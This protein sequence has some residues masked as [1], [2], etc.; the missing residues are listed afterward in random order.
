MDAAA[1]GQAALRGCGCTGRETRPLRAV[2]VVT[3]SV[4]DGFPVP[5]GRWICLQRAGRETRPLR[6]VR[7]VTPSVGDGFPVPKGYAGSDRNAR[8]T[9]GD[10]FPV[11]GCVG[12]RRSARAGRPGPYGGCGLKKKRPYHLA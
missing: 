6:A 10:G 11:P 1:W 5:L 7:I 8:P 2:R 12:A 9:V 4:G 3:P